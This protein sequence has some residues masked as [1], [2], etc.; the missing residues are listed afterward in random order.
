MTKKS[1][2]A[3]IV[4]FNRS[5]KLSNVLDALEAQTI[6]IDAIYVIDNASTDDT[7][8]VLAARSN[9]SIIPI[10]LPK[11]IGGAGGFHEG[12]KIAYE[13]GHDLFWISDDDAY[14][15][16]GAIE[17][18]VTQM[19]A[20][21][22]DTHW[23][24]SFACSNVKWTD[25]TLCEMNVPVPVWD[26]PRWYTAERPVTLV[27][28]CSFVS[29]LIPRWAV[30]EHG[31]PIKDYFIWHDDVEYTTRLARSYP[32]LFCPNSTVIHDTPDNKGV[33]FAL[34]SEQSL[35]KFSYGVRNETSRRMR[36]LGWVG[37]AAFAYHVRSQMLSGGVALKLRRSVYKSIL[38]GLKFR[39]TLHNADGTVRAK[40]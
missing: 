1:I 11:N 13:N 19:T 21:E 34:V 28:S 25:G 40:T 31:L 39:P 15:D 2:A 20:L 27:G 10:R 18:L 24:P 26:W 6:P 16:P 8:E 30:T 36:D 3:V 12:M 35:W 38:S 17:D 33:N 9:A 32:G 22:D 5:G 4:T 29:V 7:T 23:R 14:P 37:V